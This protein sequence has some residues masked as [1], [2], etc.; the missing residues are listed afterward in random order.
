MAK[1]STPMRRLKVGITS[2]DGKE[3]EGEYYTQRGKVIVHYG[4]RRKSTQPGASAAI[5][6]KCS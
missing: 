5:P 3:F 2:E 4:S 6:P 1:A